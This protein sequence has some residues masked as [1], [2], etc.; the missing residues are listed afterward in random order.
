MRIRAVAAIRTSVLIILVGTNFGADNAWAQPQCSTSQYTYTF[1][2]YCPYPIWVGESAAASNNQSYP[3][4]GNNWALAPQCTTDAVCSPGTCDR[5]SGQCTCTTSSDCPGAATCQ[6]NRCITTSTFCMPQTW[7]SGTFWP[8]TSC[9]AVGTA[10]LDCATG[11]CTASGDTDGLLDCG[12]GTTSPTNPATQFEVTSTAT[13]T[14]YDVSLVAGANVEMK[15]TPVGGHYP[16]PGI[17]AGQNEIACYVA[18][19]SDDL[20]LTCPPN[21]QVLS[22]STVIGCLDTCTQCQRTAPGQP[23]SNAAIYAALMC[24]QPITVDSSGN[25]PSATTTCSGT[26]V[27]S[28][29]YQDMYCVQ[30]FEEATGTSPRLNAQASSNQGTATAFSQ[31][32]CFPGTTFILP[33]YPNVYQP[34]VGSGVC[35][36]ASAPQTGTSPNV[37]PN[38]N[39]YGWHDYVQNAPL[40]CNTF[41]DGHVCGGYLTGQVDTLPD[42]SKQTAT[43]PSALGY[44]CRTVTYQDTLNQMQTAHLCLPPTTSGLGVCTVDSLGLN[45]LYTGV[46]GVFNASWLKAGLQAGSGGVPYFS[47]F[48]RACGAAYSW[49]YDDAA[50]GFACYSSAPP[51]GGAAF[52]GFNVTF[53]GSQ[54]AANPSFVYKTLQ[55]C[56]IMDTRFA[57]QASGVQGPLIGNSLY[58]IPGFLSLGSNW[59]QYG[60]SANALGCGLTNPPGVAIH[61]LALVITI[62]NPNYDAFLGVSDINDLTTTLSTIALNYT[63]GQ[64][65]STM[66]LV[67]QASS[68]NIYFAMPAQLSADLLFDVVGYSVIPDAT[69]LQCTTQSSAPTTIAALGGT[70]N[71]TSPACS[72]GYTLTSGSCDSI[73]PSMKLSRDKASGQS[74]LCAATNSGASAA[75]LTAVANCCQVPGK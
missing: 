52:N 22:G 31:A 42:G 34:P 43:Y 49:Q 56:R 40:N 57:T 72:A 65:L 24:D 60:G 9:T 46:G 47:T 63:K 18:G 6:A 16:V 17:P 44:A 41:P 26:T 48:K 69:P 64:G 12:Y 71:A 36:Y 8:R 4:Q 30:N 13:S 67:P 5:R 45:P 20:D 7:T 15:V 33:T 59:S 1:T 61:S 62:L 14:N 73:S 2:N 10:G 50:S 53:C 25:T 66:Y 28:P 55:P 51:S 37:S 29:T 54:A 35:L 70:G 23:T 74:W 68:N 32:D 75:N 58:H 19:C 21:L 3:P 39:D 38:F 11:Q 27:V